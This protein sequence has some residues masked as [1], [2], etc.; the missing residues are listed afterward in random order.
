MSGGSYLLK[1]RQLQKT[2]LYTRKVLGNWNTTPGGSDL[3]TKHRIDQG[4]LARTRDTCNENV[5]FV[6]GLG[7][8]VISLN[9]IV[10]LKRG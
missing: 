5:G 9:K 7:D 8:V 3:F 2:N 4:T 6:A 1:A 10:D